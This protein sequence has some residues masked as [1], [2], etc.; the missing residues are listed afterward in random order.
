VARHLWQELG[1]ESILRAIPTRRADQRDDF[2]ERCWVLVANRLCSPGSEHGLAGWLETDFV[3]DRSGRRWIAQWR[4]DAQRL[5]SKSPRVRVEAKQLKGWY[6]TLDWL[7][8]RKQEIETELFLRLRT[9]FN[10]QPDL[11]FYDLTST[12][13]EGQ[14]PVGYA[15]YGHSRD[16]RAGNRQVVVGVV[17]VDGW[18]IAHQVFA[19]NW[20]DSST[21]PHVLYDLQKRF[22][23]RRVVFV[24]DRGMITADNIETL[25]SKDHGYVMGV[26]RRRRPD[27]QRWIAAAT[28]PWTE[29]EGGI[30]NSE[31]SNPAR[32]LVQEVESGQKALRVFVVHSDDRHAYE[33]AM[34]ERDMQRTREQLQELAARIARGKLKAAEK[35]GAAAGRVLSRH[36]GHRYFDWSYSKGRFE[37]HEHPDRLPM[38]EAVEGKYIL[39]T[40]EPKLSAQDAVRIYKELNEVERGFR[41]LKDVLHMRP[42]FH[43]SEERVRAHIFVAALALLVHR[44]LERKLKTSGMDLSATQALGALKTVRL[45]DIARTDGKT[46][47]CLSNGSPRAAAILRA[48]GIHKPAPPPMAAARIERV[49]TN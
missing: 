49:G 39:A 36:R 4:P 11:V 37:F 43:Q 5:A 45:I 28:G 18:P 47:R 16:S 21:V 2:A 44:A 10:L 9:L 23:F 25:R 22:G 20:R 15:R 40:E 24:G 8:Q 38:E 13:F 48:V 34:R 46:T 12:Y 32:T 7:L 19:G 31:K 27:V 1:F 14:G 41:C 6:R 30:V 42:V 33:K 3:C 35:V 29:C 26:P 17:M